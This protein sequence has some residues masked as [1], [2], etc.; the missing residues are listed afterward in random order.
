MITVGSIE[1]PGDSSSEDISEDS[2]EDSSVP[3]KS[4]TKRPNK[5][6]ST[7]IRNVN[8][9]PPEEP[10]YDYND[11]NENDKK[12]VRNVSKRPKKQQSTTI[13]NVN[14]T[15][16]SN[17]YDDDYENGEQ[18]SVVDPLDQ[19][20]PSSSFKP[21]RIPSTSSVSSSSSLIFQPTGGF[22]SPSSL[23]TGIVRPPPS[24]SSSSQPSSGT[25]HYVCQL[26]GGC[27]VRIQAAGFTI[28]E[29]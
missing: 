4:V 25:C 5:L 27:S 18:T 10:S 28:N 2:P 12:H 13:R 9:T 22:V 26:S 29:S 11:N 19:N 15:P 8:I 17:D 23:I 6:P 20:V 24:F 14:I 3:I 7:T 21:P 1:E 16:P